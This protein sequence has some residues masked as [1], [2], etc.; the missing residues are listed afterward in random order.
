MIAGNGGAPAACKTIMNARTRKLVAVDTAPRAGKLPLRLVLVVPFLLQ[1]FLAVGLTGWLSFRHGRAAVDDIAASLRQELTGHVREYLRSYLETA[2]LINRLNRDAFALGQLDSHDPEEL[3]QH[4]RRQLDHFAAVAFI[5]FGSSHGGAAGAG[6]GLDGSMT[7]DHTDASPEHGLIAGTRYEYL[8]GPNGERL[9]QLKADP[10]FDAR[11]RP[12]YTAAREAGEAV[13]SEVY[14]LFAEQALAI[15]ASLPVYGGGRELVGVLGV[16]LRLAGIDAFLRQLEIGKTGRS[17]ILDRSGLLV[18]SSTA[19]GPLIAGASGRGPGRLPAAASA[20]R[21]I[22]GATWF[23]DQRFGDLAAID[24]GHQLKFDLAGERQLMQVAPLVDDYGL[25]WLLVIV[26]PEADFMEPIAANRRRTILLCLAAFAVA[27][28][29]GL[30]TSRWIARPILRLNQASRAI[31]A[32]RLDHTVE[33]A[34]ARELGDLARSFNLMAG[35]LQGSFGELEARV[36]QRTAELEQAKET[37]EVANRAKT[38]FLANISHEIRTPLASV[39]GYVELLRDRALSAEEIDLYL[40][41]IRTSGGHLNRLLS[42]LLDVSRIEAGRLELDVRPCEL[43]ELL[44]YLSSAFEPLARERGLALEVLTEDRLPWRFSADGMRLRQILSNLLSNA[45]KYTDRGHV[46][47]TVECEPPPGEPD[48]D[49]DRAVLAFS[50]ADTGPGISEE[51]QRHLFQRFTQLEAPVRISDPPP[52]A[53]SPGARR[54]TGFGLGLSITRQLAELMGGEVGVTSRPGSGSTFTVRL[55]VGGCDAWGRRRKPHRLP[56][57]AELSELPA[58]AGRV[59]IADD[60]TALQLLCTRM[61]ERWG[62]ECATAGDGREAVRKARQRRFDAILMDWQMPSRAGGAQTEHVDGLAAT[63]RL[64]RHGVDTPILAL[65]AAAMDGDRERCLAAGC[66]GYLVKPIDFKELHRMLSKTLP[67]GETS[68]RSKTTPEGRKRPSAGRRAKT[69]QPA[70]PRR[71]R[72]G[73]TELEELVQNFV[74]GL[75]AKVSD[76][77]A[78]LLASDWETFDAAVH[79]LAGTAGSYGLDDVFQAAEALEGAAAV[80]DVVKNFKNKDLLK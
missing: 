43:A 54:A 3:T 76:L 67:D 14:P 41:I 71:A 23:L 44:A 80:R 38:R 77:R 37:A 22:G 47:L 35:Q 69:A 27:T 45:I 48:R 70:S 21:L 66:D 55:P 58:L 9:R 74:K 32:G 24:R 30:W 11:R 59:L 5:F 60:S 28:V 64:R 18:A 1:L 53:G 29:L 12:W 73:D 75:P 78:A 19:E 36:L 8:A 57:A 51:D 50:V 33:E 42:D 34:G 16:D 26:V 63:T 7:V 56:A 62:L 40:E 68:R 15:A 79:Q 72:D 49:G 20:E 46:R 6:R 65:T 39:L 13:W 2:H 31:A 17:F 25:D 61:L 52:S 10:G 4:F